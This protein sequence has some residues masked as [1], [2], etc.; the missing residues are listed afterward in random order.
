MKDK[1]IVVVGGTG[2]IGMALIRQLA[3]QGARLA[4]TGRD[5]A[6]LASAERAI[7]GL[8]SFRCEITSEE[9]VS[10][11]FSH[12]DCI[13]HIV[14]LAG[15]SGGG[16]FIETPSS[17]QRYVMEERVWGAVYAVRAAVPKMRGGSITLTSG[18]FSSRPPAGG[19]VMLVSA[20]AAVEG[21]ARGLARELAPIRV[22]AISFGVVRSSRH[23]HMGADQEAYY[24]R[25]GNSLPAGRVGEPEHAAQA[26][27]FAMQ[28]DYLTGEVLRVDG[29]ARLV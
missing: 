12:F 14:V 28:N 9:S 1:Q 23:R 26:I 15:S 7:R 5:A 21:L 13:D 22:N 27:V 3:A 4:L 2:S 17:R 11:V 6:K 19:A 29:G 24:Q 25:L 16:P 20:L 8:Q 18:L 10:Q